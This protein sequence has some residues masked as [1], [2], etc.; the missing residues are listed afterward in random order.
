MRTSPTDRLGLALFGKGKRAILSQL[1]GNPDRRFFVRELARAAG[2]TASTLTRDLSALAD[3][4]VIERSQEGRQVYFRANR[5][6]PVFEE[7]RG[8]V[9]K[10]FGIA[11]VLRAMLAPVAGRIQLAAVYGSVARGEQS[12]RSDVDLL[13]IGDVR[14]GDFADG[15]LEAE[16]RLGRPISPSIYSPSEFRVRSGKPPFLESI[17]SK[18]LVF[19]I[20]DEHELKRLRQGKTS[21]PH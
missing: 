19:L 9:T 20:G 21:K 4:G 8:L 16:Q 14:S 18:P 10:T 5:N 3:A 2:L 6:S 12:A 11:D 7:L 13:I 1:M 17:L 15:L